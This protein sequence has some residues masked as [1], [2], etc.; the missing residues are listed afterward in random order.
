M[1]KLIYIMAILALAALV[2]SGYA[3]ITLN[4]VRH[5][6]TSEVSFQEKHVLNTP[7]LD[8]EMDRYGLIT[9]YEFRITNDAGPA[10]KLL[11]V[12]ASKQKSDFVVALKKDKVI[13]GDF[14]AK[15]FRVPY[16]ID[17]IKSDPKNLRE[18]I[19]KGGNRI[20]LQQ[21]IEPGETHSVRVGISLYPYDEN[22]NK[23]ID[24]ALISLIFKFNNKKNYTIRQGFPIVPL[25]E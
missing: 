3:V 22:K 2:L 9:I 14:G 7:I 19:K 21:S 16:S 10:V 12:G 23:K 13:G 20:H 17:E 15:L 1:K 24:L 6:A 5:A 25:H 8:Q 18:C 4:Q 11:S